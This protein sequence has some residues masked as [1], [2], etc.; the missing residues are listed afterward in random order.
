MR[1]VQFPESLI[2][3]I[4]HSQP[5]FF[6]IDA[7]IY[8][9][10]HSN[11]PVTY[12]IE[13]L[14]AHSINCL[15]DVRS[16]AASAYS[17]QYNQQ[18]LS[19]SLKTKG[20]T[21]LHFAGEFGARHTDPALLDT[22]GKVDFSKVRQTQSFQSGVERLQQGLSRGFTVA[23]M[24]AEANPFECHRFSMIAV[25]LARQGFSVRH[26]LKDK[27]LLTNEALEKELL[28][29]YAKKIPH[30]S[31]F[32]PDVTIEAQLAVAYRLH[33]QDIAYKA[34]DNTTVEV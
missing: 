32:E 34:A 1:P 5:G 4:S 31:I 24:C 23:I 6:V 21:Y 2:T 8:T 11:H 27:S 9:I 13:L 29:K 20:I 18:A 17:P 22:N 26:I 3:F 14:Q 30:P 25:Q 28:K 15:V 12:F 19:R 16:V 10:G 33:N 7:T